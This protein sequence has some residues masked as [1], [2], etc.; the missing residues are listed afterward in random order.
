MTKAR[1][2]I[3]IDAENIA[4]RHWRQIAEHAAE[5][6]MIQSCRIFGDFT[7]G[8]LGKWLDLANA[9]GLQPVL[10]LSGGKNSS[11]IAITVA[12]MDTLY[13]SRIEAIYIVSSDQDFAALAQRVRQAGIKVIGLGLANTPPSLRLACTSFTVLGDATVTS[14]KAAKTA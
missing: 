5:T 6:G 9:E 13:T 2:A 10:R 12:A 3:F 8:R 4:A 11:D 7:E 1:I 14:L